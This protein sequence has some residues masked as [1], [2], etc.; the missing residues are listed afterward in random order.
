MTAGINGYCSSILPSYTFSSACQAIFRT[1]DTATYTTGIPQDDGSTTEGILLLVAATTTG[2]LLTTSISD[3][4]AAGFVAV[5]VVPPLTLVHKPTDL[6]SGSGPV[7]EEDAVFTGAAAKITLGGGSAWGG[8]V[9]VAGVLLASALA[10]GML[11][12][13]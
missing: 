5:S 8:V 3:A 4:E 2:K 11:V 10:G 6:A 9:G 1:E 7:E 12:L 13:A